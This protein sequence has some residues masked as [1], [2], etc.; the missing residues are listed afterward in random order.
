MA[1]GHAQRAHGG[2]EMSR[3]LEVLDLRTLQ[4][5]Y[6]F[7]AIDLLGGVFS[8]LSLAFKPKLDVIATVAYSAVV[9]SLLCFFE[10]FSFSVCVRKEGRNESSQKGEIGLGRDRHPTSDH[11]QPARKTEAEAGGGEG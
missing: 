3:H 5:T 4:G 2:S 9:V 6:Y 11:H 7:M 1:R 8:I 10:S